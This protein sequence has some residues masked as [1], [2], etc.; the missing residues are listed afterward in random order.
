MIPLKINN[1]QH[2]KNI[3]SIIVLTFL[4]VSCDQKQNDN[5]SDD[6]ADMEMQEEII[7]TT[8]QQVNN[9]PVPPLPPVNNQDVI[10]K[11]IIKDGRLGLQVDNLEYSKS[12]I[13][14]LVRY[15][16]GYYDEES[17][18]NYDYESSYNLRIRVPSA[19]FESFI[20]EVETGEGE[21]KYKEIDVRDVTDQFIDLETRLQIKKNYLKRYNELLAKAQSVKDILEIEEEIRGIEEEIESTTGRIKYLSDLVEYSKLDLTI[22]I[23][24]DFKYNPV[25]RGNFIEK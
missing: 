16:G 24:K 21:I 9:P 14:T 6:L 10:N 8:R 3:L 19:N 25:N 4:F 12:R 22:T 5:I 17:F 11:K 13:D 15:H 7:P 1:F 2:M 23:P 20:N 18:N